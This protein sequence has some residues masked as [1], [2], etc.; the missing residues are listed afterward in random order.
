ME[1]LK[2]AC[3]HCGSIDAF[4]RLKAKLSFA[5]LLGETCTICDHEV[6]F[7]DVNDMRR[8]L[9]QAIGFDSG[10]VAVSAYS[11]GRFS[12][13]ATGRGRLRLLAGP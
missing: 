13:K 7:A 2:V 12:A 8:R 4:T 3:P 10:V 5:S 6:S 9:A 11:L 1:T